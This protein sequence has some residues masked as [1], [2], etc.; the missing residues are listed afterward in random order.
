MILIQAWSIKVDTS[1]F[2][3][4]PIPLSFIHIIYLQTLHEFILF[5]AVKKPAYIDEKEFTSLTF[6]LPLNSKSIY[7]F[8]HV[9]LGVSHKC[10]MQ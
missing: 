10:Q 4:S 7:T 9:H 1:C 2:F 5:F 6:I 8:C 3:L